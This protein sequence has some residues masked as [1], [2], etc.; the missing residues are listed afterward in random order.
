[1][2]HPNA[3]RRTYRTRGLWLGGGSAQ[4]LSQGIHRHFAEIDFI[5][6]VREAECDGQTPVIDGIWKAPD[7]VTGVLTPIG[8]TDTIRVVINDF[9]LTGGDGYTAFTGLTNVAQPGDDL[10]QV[11]IDWITAHSPVDPVVDHRI[12]EPAP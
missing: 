9:M 12:V 4:A 8:P 2:R 1:M 10:L 7:G 3:G 11:T 6:L 5:N